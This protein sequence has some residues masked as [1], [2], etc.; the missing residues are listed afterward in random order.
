[1][2]RKYSFTLG[3][4][5]NNGL[6]AQLVRALHSHCRGH[7]FESSRV[8]YKILPLWK[9]FYYDWIRKMQARP[10]PRQAMKKIQQDFTE[11]RY[12]LGSTKIAPL[13]C[14]ICVLKTREES[15]VGAKLVTILARQVRKN[16]QQIIIFENPVDSKDAGATIYLYFHSW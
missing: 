11:W 12:P 16:Y 7:W 2:G 6:V 9:D 8:H 3:T 5:K 15:K 1:M 13:W 4:V 14:D 10:A